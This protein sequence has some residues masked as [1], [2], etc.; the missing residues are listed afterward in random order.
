[1]RDYVRNTAVEDTWKGAWTSPVTKE[2]KIK[3]LKR[4]NTTP[5]GDKARQITLHARRWRSWWTWPQNN[6]KI[7]RCTV[8][9]GATK[10]TCRHFWWE[11]KLLL[12]WRTV[13]YYLPNYKYKTSFDPVTHLQELPWRGHPR[14]G[15]WLG[16]LPR[17]TDKR[18][19][20]CP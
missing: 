10:Y 5:H 18:P 8:G 15:K 9:T 6:L 2:V 1:M 20:T 16:L 4:Q 19:A 7:S 3:I 14:V 12:L 17:A 11:C 13:W